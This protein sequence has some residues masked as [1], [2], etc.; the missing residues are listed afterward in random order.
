MRSY[1]ISQ[2]EILIAHVTVA[3]DGRIT[4]DFSPNDREG[5]WMSEAT[6][7][8]IEAALMRLPPMALTTV[9]GFTLRQRDPH[10]G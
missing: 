9:L 8:A 2:G 1:T 4:W 3:D 7:T 6:K 5:Y 10:D